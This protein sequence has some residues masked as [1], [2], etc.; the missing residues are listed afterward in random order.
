MEA[1]ALLAKSSMKVASF[2]VGG[3]VKLPGPSLKQPNIY[4]FGTPYQD[5]YND[6][7]KQNRDLYMKNGLL[8]MLE[9]NMG[10]K[11]A[12]ERW[13]DNRAFFNVAFTFEERVMDQLVED[14]TF[15]SQGTMKTLLVVNMDVRD[16]KT[17]A[18]NAAPQALRLCQM[19]GPA[20]PSFNTFFHSWE[21]S[22][23]L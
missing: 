7:L 6:L 15:R 19:V 1:H 17:E 10:V 18:A 8:P 9:R 20:T 13:Q 2:G 5:I 23:W 12:P 3:H 14:M 11:V 16:N 4:K 21:T 22:S